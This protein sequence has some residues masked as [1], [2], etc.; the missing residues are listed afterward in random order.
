MTIIFDRKVIYRPLR[1]IA[2]LAGTL[3]L[4]ATSAIAQQAERIISFD[5]DITIEADTSVVIAERIELISNG[6]QIKRGITRDLPTSVVDATGVSRTLSF[7]I[8]RVTRDGETIP[9]RSELDTSVERVYMGSDDIFLPAGRHVFEIEYIANNAVD[10]LN[11]RDQLFW[12]VTGTDWTLPI[13]KA[14]ATVHLP[15]G[16][17]I[18]GLSAYTGR[19]GTLGSDFTFDTKSD[20]VIQFDTIRRLNPGE[21]LSVRVSWP[22]GILRRPQAQAE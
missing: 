4:A 8:V 5:V 6:D 20:R 12:D 14:H 3:L 21:G 10:F 2:V 11:G 13:E 18:V 17:R 9:H 15:V 7:E 19:I 1:L 16:T 22:S